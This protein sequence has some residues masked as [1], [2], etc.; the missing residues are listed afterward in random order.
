ML[1]G[2]NADKIVGSIL[3][4]CF[5]NMCNDQVIK[6]AAIRWFIIDDISE[7][8]WYF[9]MLNGPIPFYVILTSDISDFSDFPNCLAGS[10]V[11]CQSIFTYMITEE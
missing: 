7:Q 2:C 8:Q 11:S 10:W 9:Y 3:H 1:D 6:D 4:D 5:N